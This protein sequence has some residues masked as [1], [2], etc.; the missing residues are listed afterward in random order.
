[1]KLQEKQKAIKLR[2]KGY[3]LKEI[4]ELLEVSKSSVSLW[5][6]GL[7]L[8]RKAEN[9]LCERITKG[10]II[11]ASNKKE[12][13]R[14]KSLQY[15]RDAYD[16]FSSLDQNALLNKSLCSLLYWCEGGKH[17]NNS[18]QFTNSDPKLIQA[19]LILF[20]KSFKIKEDKF[21]VCIHLHDY[22]DVEQQMGFWQKI[23]SIPKD[24]FIKPY[25]KKSTHHRIHEE[26]QGCCQIRYYNADIN[27]EI[28]MTAKACLDNIIGA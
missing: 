13:T 11:S 20:R 26:Y 24:Q 12:Q 27:R 19:F 10:Q 3:S 28:T 14:A 2:M 5:V 16:N 18:V 1:M 17:G 15:Y 6:T 25:I 7:S 8:S 22:H 9:R 4:S 23:T 21:R